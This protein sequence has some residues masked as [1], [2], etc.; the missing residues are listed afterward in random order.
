MRALLSRALVCG[1]SWLAGQTAPAAPAAGGDNIAVQDMVLTVPEGWSL[2]QDAKDDGTIILG[3]AKGSE[4]LTLY[5]K[6]ATSL[7]M[8]QIFVNG[9][10]VVRDVRNLP[11][12][13]FTWKVLETSKTAANRTNHVASFLTELN[14]YSYYG[15]SRSADGTR[16]MEN[17]STFLTELR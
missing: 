11:R 4:Y 15:F 16:S 7:D 13:R 3:F 12:N 1:L 6:R 17:V 14:G 2:K 10:T 8:R 9:S 5:V